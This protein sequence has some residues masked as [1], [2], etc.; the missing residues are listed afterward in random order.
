MGK[1]KVFT[2]GGLKALL[3]QIVQIEETAD[4]SASA[5]SDL[6]ADLAAFAGLAI[7]ELCGK[8][9]KARSGSC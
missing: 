3:S 2:P 7:Q 5:V 4:A 9:D 6:G 8:R 1:K